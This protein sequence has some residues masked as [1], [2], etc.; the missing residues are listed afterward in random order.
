MY[1]A[2]FRTTGFGLLHRTDGALYLKA[3][4]GTSEICLHIQ[5]ERPLKLAFKHTK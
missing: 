3:K 4:V 5:L 1:W 2:V